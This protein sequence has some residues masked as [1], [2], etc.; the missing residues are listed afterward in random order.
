MCRE[1]P[2]DFVG[3]Q[4]R[5]QRHVAAGQSFADRHQ[6][7]RDSLMLAGEHL[8]GAAESGGHFIGNQEHV[9]LGAELTNPLQI[10]GRGGQHACC[11]LHERLDD[12]A[13]QFAVTIFENLFDRV[14]AGH[15]AGRVGQTERATIAI[16][17]VG[18][19]G[20]EEQ[21]LESRHG[22]GRCCPR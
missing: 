8:A 2:V 4:R 22:R 16:G 1:R 19:G 13:G 3:G 10:A 6:V 12:E 9:V 15:L 21:R 20:G 17:R 5:G 7:R 11:G 18:F 14:E